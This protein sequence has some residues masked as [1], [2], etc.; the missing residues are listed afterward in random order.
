MAP[1]RFRLAPDGSAEIDGLT[2]VP[3][4]NEQFGL[5]IDEDTYTT[6]GGYLMGRIGRRAHVGEAIEVE[7]RI[8]RVVA[9]DGLRVS[10]VWLSTPSPAPTGESAAETD[11][12]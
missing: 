2:L 5:H 10:R 4:I 1:A 7:G 8:M 12:A 9:I 3:D 11:R 6:I